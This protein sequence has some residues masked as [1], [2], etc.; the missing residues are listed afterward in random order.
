MQA[1]PLYEDVA[2]APPGGK[3]WWLSASDGERIRAATWPVPAGIETRGTVL[4]FPGRTEYVEKYGHAA[5]AYSAQG[6]AFLTLD[7]RGQGLTARAMADRRLGHV[8]AFEEYQRDVAAAVELAIAQDLPKPWFLVGHSMGGCIALRSLHADLDVRA[9]AFSAPMWGMQM[10][11]W[12]RP[13]AWMSALAAP[14]PQVGRRLTPRTDLDHALYVNPFE[15]NNLTTDP[16]MWDF[17]RRQLDAYPDLTLGG[18]TIRWLRAA[19][20]ETR[21]LARLSPPDIPALTFLGTNERIVEPGAI[22]RLMQRWPRGR[23]EMIEGAE[24]EIMMERPDVRDRFF[25]E[26]AAHFLAQA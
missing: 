3:A 14:F 20:F 17:M 18:P 7:W 24:H 22:R 10:E 26:S 4:L 8:I 12:E 23:L 6:F 11:A 21:A 13:L 16:V 9:V 2:D 1:A 15:S 19:L 25:A 5:R